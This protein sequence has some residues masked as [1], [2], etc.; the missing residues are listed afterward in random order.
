LA[1]SLAQKI[2]RLLSDAMGDFIATA[3]LKKNCDLIGATPDN[4]TAD[5]L[6]LLAEHIEKSVSFFND[7]DTA[8]KVSE[9]IRALR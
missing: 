9:Q 7:E 1:N 8:R 3:T 5:Q 6:P 4:L 2:E